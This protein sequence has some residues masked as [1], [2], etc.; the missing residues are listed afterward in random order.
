MRY[1]PRDSWS[2]TS[3]GTS[4][5]A[6]QAAPSQSHAWWIP[7][8]P[9]PTEQERRTFLAAAVIIMIVLFLIAVLIR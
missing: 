6:F 5:S 4:W 1:A 2:T 8:V 9:A 3:R 7:S